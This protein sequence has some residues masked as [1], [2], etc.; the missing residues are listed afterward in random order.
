M[1][2]H[3]AREQLHCMQI[4]QMPRVSSPMNSMTN[5][6]KSKASPDGT[7][8]RSECDDTLGWMTRR[9]AAE[10]SATLKHLLHH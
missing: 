9:Q 10:A 5:A 6:P 3:K 2:H 1:L 8:T 4:F 7:S